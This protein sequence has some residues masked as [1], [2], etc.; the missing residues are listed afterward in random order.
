MIPWSL[1]CAA[2]RNKI[3]NLSLQQKCYGY[4]FPIKNLFKLKK[5]LKGVAYNVE[6]HNHTRSIGIFCHSRETPSLNREEE[7]NK[8]FGIL[9]KHS[10]E[11]IKYP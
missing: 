2:S 10:K 7:I 6:V 9:S 8:L 3:I 5:W 1:S 4:I 11:E